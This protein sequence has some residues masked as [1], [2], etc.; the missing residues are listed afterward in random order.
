MNLELC[1]E[2]SGEL[3]GDLGKVNM[4]DATRI[5]IALGIGTG[6]AALNFAGLWIT[7]NRMLPARHPLAVYVASLVAR[8][9]L[10]LGVFYSV[11]VGMDWVSLLVCLAAFMLARLLMVAWIGS[12]PQPVSETGSH[13]H[14]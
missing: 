3:Q 13:A 10:I 12:V 4:F 2:W 5:L 11:L 6:L 14:G 8:M 1:S 7:V 9:A